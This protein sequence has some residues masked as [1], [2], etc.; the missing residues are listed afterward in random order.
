VL[1]GKN[2][3][4][5]KEVLEQLEKVTD[6]YIQIDNGLQQDPVTQSYYPV[7]SNYE[8]ALRLLTT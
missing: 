6:A 4:A 2:P 1:E 3:G 7:R 5:N 8:N